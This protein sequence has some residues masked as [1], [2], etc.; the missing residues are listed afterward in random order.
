MIVGVAFF[1][2]F[3]EMADDFTGCV[4]DIESDFGSF[5]FF[6]GFGLS[7]GFGFC[8]GYGLIGSCGSG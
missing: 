3:R 6:F 7:A 1:F 2:F 8:F 5:G 4:E